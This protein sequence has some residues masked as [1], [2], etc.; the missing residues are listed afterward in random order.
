MALD[1]EFLPLMLETVVVK[2]QASLD[3]YG[4]QT[5]AASGDSYRARLIFEDRLMHDQNGRE[6]VETGRAILFGA[7]ASITTQHNIE[8]PDGSTP[9]ITRVDTIQDEDGDHHSVIGFGL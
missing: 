1:R 8:L 7:A 2:A 4:K 5:F 9:K 3:K 6:V